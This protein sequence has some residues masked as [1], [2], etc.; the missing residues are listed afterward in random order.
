MATKWVFVCGGD[1][2][3]ACSALAGTVSDQPLGQQHDSCM[4]DSIPLNAGEDCPKYTFNQVGTERYG[5]GGASA[6]VFFDV[7]VECC[8]GST[9]GETLEIDLG[10]EPGDHGSID[11]EFAEIEADVDQ[12]AQ[13]L[14]EGCPPDDEDNVI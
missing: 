7:E 13:E 5:P 12:A 3:G 9:I 4:C 1:A 11:D 10:V 14:A 6:R 2:C 8:D